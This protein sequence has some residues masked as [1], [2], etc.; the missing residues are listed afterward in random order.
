M[1]QVKI[2]QR[3]CETSSLKSY[4][5]ITNDD[6]NVLFRQMLVKRVWMNTMRK[7]ELE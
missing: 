3:G 1:T 5:E 2:I 4:L 6:K 7:E